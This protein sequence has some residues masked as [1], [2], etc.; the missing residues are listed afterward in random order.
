[1]N[2][3]ALFSK[4]GHGPGPDPFDEPPYPAPLFGVMGEFAGPEELV[5]AAARAREAGFTRLDACT[6]YPVEG[7]HEALSPKQTWLPLLVLLGGIAGASGVFFFEYWYHVLS[8]PLS[9][10]NRPLNSWPA[11]IVPAFEG[12]IL[13]AAL[14]AV[15]GMLALNGLPR[16]HHPLFNVDRFE[17]A[18]SDGFFLVLEADDPKFVA[19]QA[20]QFL[21]SSG[22]KEVFDVPR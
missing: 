17:A 1:M 15:L 2:G 14:T 20:R 16:P 22:A 11:F 18:S 7:L 13:I 8:Y 4:P 21:R 19:E 5:T 6:P 10:G 12:T 3:D 9:S